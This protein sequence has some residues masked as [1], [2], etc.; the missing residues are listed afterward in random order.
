MFLP[1]DRVQDFTKLNSQELLRNTQNSVCSTEVN[2]AFETL[3]KKRELQKNAS[4]NNDQL[5]TQL[6]D[7]INRNEQLFAVIES[8][9]ARDNLI[10]QRDLYLKKKAWM[11]YDELKVKFDEADNDVKKLQESINGKK[12]ALL[13]FEK[14]QQEISGQ[15][16]ALKNSISASITNIRQVQGQVDQIFNSMKNIN[17]EIRQSKQKLKNA[18]ENAKNHANN[19]QELQL[20]IQLDKNEHEKEKDLIE[21]EE[22]DGKVRELDNKLTRHKSEIE[23]YMKSIYSINSKLDNEIT[24]A[25]EK[26]KRALNFMTDKQKQ[27]IITLR[28]HFEDAHRAFEWLTENRNQFEGHVFNPI[29]LEITTTELKYSQY[30]ENTINMRDLQMFLCTNKNDVIKLT[31]I[32]RSDMKLKVNIGFTED[33]ENLTFVSSRRINEFPR[34]YGIYAHLIDIVDGP[35]P[36]LN[37]LC[38]LYNLHNVILAD[39]RIERNASKLP[40]DIRLFFSS[41][42]RF[43]VNVSRYANQKSLQS[44]NIFPRNLLHVSVNQEEVDNEQ[45]M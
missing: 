12:K 36:V 26:S 45:Q 17:S 23:R 37:Y 13:P 33:T 28:N 8:S 7:N 35:A 34:E 38:K 20:K 6:N 27:R 18:Y 16:S 25:I 24:P 39:D 44:D 21:N 9:R 31:K 19:V 30:L 43:S 41:N 29:I 4:K 42:T 22:I 15:K 2:E 5:Q 1:Q 3:I 14:K 10:Q 11:E 40:D 32:L